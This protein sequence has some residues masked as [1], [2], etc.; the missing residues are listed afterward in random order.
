VAAGL[1][2]ERSA[3]HFAPVFGMVCRELEI[4]LVPVIRLFLFLTLR[5]L[6]SAAV[7]L[8]IAG[9]LEGQSLQWRMAPFAEALVIPASEIAMEDAAQTAPLLDLLQGGQDR[10]YSR[11]FQS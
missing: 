7:R 10:L 1:R 5:G 8:G 2:S 3:G 6:V 11:L 9:T 4:D